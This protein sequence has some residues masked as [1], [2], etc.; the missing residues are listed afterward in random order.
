V[1]Q[2]YQIIKAIRENKYV[3]AKPKLFATFTTEW[4]RAR[5]STM[6]PG[7]YRSY[8][9]ALD[10]WLTPEF[11][12]F[13]M[14]DIT[15]PMVKAFAYKLLDQ[16]LSGKSVQN[17]LRLL[18]SLF[19]EG[20]DQEVCATNPAHRL[21]I[22]LPD[23][24]EARVVPSK[25]DLR[26]T[27]RQLGKTPVLQALLATAAMT[28]CR[29][30]ELCGLLWS[31]IDWR[32]RTIRIERSLVRV[33]QSRA[34]SFK[35]LE[36]VCSMAFALAPPKSKKGRRSI[37]MPKELETLL[38]HL[39]AM[40]DEKNPF[41]FQGT[42]GPIDMD[43]IADPLHEAQDRAGVKRFGLHGT[44]HFFASALHDAGA[45]LAQARDALGHSSI[46]MTGHYTH[47]LEKGREHV[48]SV[49]REFSGVSN[50]LPGGNPG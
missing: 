42:A 25:A 3:D 32:T 44:R 21:K 48:E 22:K 4:L 7:T 38:Q 26:A 16:D 13:E 12:D 8:K 47:A 34:G 49:G 43:E 50:L 30:G 9:S 33:H 2:A 11:G 27:L 17:F 19:E 28:G 29:R 24:S 39:R 18:H 15:R 20:I 1:L 36:W 5:Q 6:K 40:S 23:D 46:N 10:K 41:V 37:S 35:N 31:E 45:S 14:N